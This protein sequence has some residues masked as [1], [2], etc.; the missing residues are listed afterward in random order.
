MRGTRPMWAL[1]VTT[2]R[3]VTRALGAATALG[4]TFVAIR[5]GATASPPALGVVCIGSAFVT[6]AVGAWCVLGVPRRF[7]VP[8]LL[9]G[10]LAVQ[11]AAATGP[12]R[13]SDDLYR[14][15]WDGRVQAAG[16][17]P[18]RYAP[19][20]P[21][22]VGLR[23]PVLWPARSNWCVQPST[24]DAATGEALTPGCTLI[25]RPWVHT[26]YPPVAEAV[27]LG[28]HVLSPPG[29]GYVPV[30]ALAVLAALATTVLLVWGLF[31][32]GA[33][34]RRAV[35]WAWCPTVAIEA[36]NTAHI[37][38]VAALITAAALLVLAQARRR[39]WTALGGALLGLAAAC[40]LTPLLVV[41]SVLRRRPVTVLFAM[42]GAV[43][44]VYLPYVVHA[45]RGVLGYLPGYL[46]EEGYSDGSR[47]ALLTMVMQASSAAPAAAVVIAGAAAWLIR[48]GD[49]DQPWRAAATLIGITLL[50]ISP[51]Y[52][53]YAVLLVLVVALGGPA[54]WIV[55]AAAA[56]VAQYHGELGL[57]G[58][59]AERLAYGL[60]LAI[61]VA[62]W[63]RRRRNAIS[64]WSEDTIPAVDEK[65][66]PGPLTLS[67]DD[68]RVLAVWAA[69]CAERTLA[70]FEAKAPNDNRP[71]AAVDGARAFARG[72]KRIGELRTLAARAHAAARE[73]EDLAAEAA[74]R[75]AGHAAAVAHMA[76]HARGAP[77][78][79]AK[80]AELAAPN[81]PEA[82]DDEV[83]WALGHATAAVRDA[84][85]RLPPPPAAGGRLA[86]VISD[87]HQAV[88]AG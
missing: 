5:W 2:G 78:Y 6:F 38:V 83:L 3:G 60:A 86:S 67:E 70:L 79:A 63:L 87:L 37:D 45:G 4:L 42:V 22:L 74:A 11:L 32:T 76:A 24:V 66:R 40:K 21:E 58:L 80:A 43:T 20:A 81:N 14:Y 1:K 51:G 10:G 27:F 50:V 28:I 8:L 7:A 23:D 16:V 49:P 26:I 9:G 46:H 54:R 55:V 59:L 25:N 47:F 19:A 57:P 62:A 31:R 69:D 84:L 88:A 85:R 36:G 61:V 72:D 77:A 41:P 18:Y 48:T 71:R 15:V 65:R 53:W 64:N 73:T 13:S 33:D 82:A 68:R 39:P 34:P 44:A 29:S 30:R 12:P 35:L 52:P 56:Y 75:A 17:D